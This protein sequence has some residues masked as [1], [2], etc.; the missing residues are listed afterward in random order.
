[1]FQRN[2]LGFILVFLLLSFFL[3]FIIWG[4]QGV[5]DLFEFQKE[6]QELS[7]HSAVIEQENVNL[8]RIIERLKHDP[9]YVERIARTELGMVQKNET[10]L[11]FSRRKQ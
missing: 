7:Q 6:Y 4:D 11:Q 2:R 9:E 10:I 5:I 3:F 8:H 1:M